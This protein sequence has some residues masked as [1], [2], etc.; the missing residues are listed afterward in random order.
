MAPEHTILSSSREPREA[1]D[2][3]EVCIDLAIYLLIKFSDDETSGDSSNSEYVSHIVNYFA[4]HLRQHA[5]HD[6]KQK[7]KIKTKKKGSLEQDHFTCLPSALTFFK[8]I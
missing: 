6:S 3:S 4:K 8:L 7:A 2:I 1:K 5:T